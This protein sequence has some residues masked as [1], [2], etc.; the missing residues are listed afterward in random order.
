MPR[1][2]WAYQRHEN[3]LR[4]HRAGRGHRRGRAGRPCDCRTPGVLPRPR[5]CQ[6][7]GV[8][9]DAVRHGTGAAVASL[10]LPSPTE[11]AFARALLPAIRPDGSA[12][13][14]LCT[15]A[16]ALGIDSCRAPLLAL[17]AARAAAALEGRTD[18]ED[19]DILLAARLVLAPARRGFRRIR[20]ARPSSRPIPASRTRLNR[21]SP[22]RTRQTM[23]RTPRATAPRR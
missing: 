3:A 22:I 8:A 7:S 20:P 19:D 2:R 11:I 14:A 13:E 5:L 21:T 10:D 9:F 15:A 17:R 16:L 18:I 12:L 6:R 4:R 23:H 1:A